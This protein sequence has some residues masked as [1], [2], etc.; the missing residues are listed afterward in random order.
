MQDPSDSKASVR[1]SDMD[2][3][4]ANVRKHVRD[5]LRIT[6]LGIEFGGVLSCVIDEHGALS[7][8]KLA[9]DEAPDTGADENPVS[10]FDAEFVLLTGTLRQLL[11][12]LGKALGGTKA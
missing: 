6:Q 8:L 1:F 12:T 5:G 3:S 9:G 4:D 10:R 2:L 11:A 7:K